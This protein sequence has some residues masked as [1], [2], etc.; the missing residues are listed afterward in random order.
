MRSE[1][2]MDLP[3]ASVVPA[4]CIGPSSGVPGE[5]GGLRFIRMTSGVGGGEGDA[6]Q[7][8]AEVGGVALPT[9]DDKS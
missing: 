1:G 3:A 9:Q 2:S 8:A 4:E 6:R 7:L 5:A